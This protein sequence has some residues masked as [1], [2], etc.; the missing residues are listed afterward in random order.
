MHRPLLPPPDGSSC[1]LLGS[2]LVP[3]PT[4]WRAEAEAEAGLL[5]R[6][7]PP[8]SPCGGSRGPRGIWWLKHQGAD[9]SLLHWGK[10]RGD[11]MA[12]ADQGGTSGSQRQSRAP[13]LLGDPTAPAPEPGSRGTGVKRTGRKQT[14]VSKSSPELPQLC[15]W[16]SGWGQ[17]VCAITEA[18][19]L[20]LPPSSASGPGP[21]LLGVAGQRRPWLILGPR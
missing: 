8:G 9:N 10:G 7:F 13:L 16:R 17:G 4:A 3:C 20:S 5:A 19:P 1:P 2:H 11:Q 15:S 14:S 18:L 6:P 12:G 21:E